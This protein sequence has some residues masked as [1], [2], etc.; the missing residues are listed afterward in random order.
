MSNIPEDIQQT[1]GNLLTALSSTDNAYR[2]QAELVLNNEWCIRDKVDILLVFLAEQ[3]ANAVLF[4]RFSIKSPN[5]QGFSV[6]DRQIDHISVPAKVEIRRLLLQ[7]FTSQQ[8]KNVRHKLADAIAE[9]A[10]DNFDWPELLPMVLHATSS[11]DAAMKESS[12]RMIATTPQIISKHDLNES[13]LKIIATCTAFVAFFEN[14][15]KSMWS[16]LSQLLPNLLN[17]LPRLLSSGNDTALASVLES[18]IDLVV[19]APK[20][21]KPMFETIISFCSQ[22]AQNTD[23]ESNARLTALELLTT[24]SETSPN[25]CKREP[26]YSTTMV[27]IT[28]K[29]MTEVCIDD[30]DC[31]EWNNTEDPTDEG[32]EDEY[33]AARQ[34]LD[35]VALKLNGQCL[36]TPLFQYLP[37]MLQSQN[38]RERQAALMALSSASE[39]CAD[40]LISEIPKLLDL[41]L[42]SL[43]DPQPRVQFACCN[44]LGQIFDSMLS[45]NNVP[46]VQTHAAAALVNFCEEA[47]KDI[48]EPYLD[49][50]LNNLLNLLKSSPKRYVQE[51]VITTIAV[52]ADAAENKFIKY[53]DTLMPL[54]VS[55][56]KSDVDSNGRTLI[57]KSIECATLIATAV[58]K[59][60]FSESANEILEIFTVLQNNLQGEDDPVKPYL[61]KGWSRVCK[62]IG[63]AFVPFLPGVIPPLL[64][65][66][67]ATQD[68]SIV[69]EDQLE[70]INQ[71]EDYEVIQL[72]GKHIAVHTSVLD[73]KASAI[74]I[75]KLYSEVLGSAFFPYVLEIANEIVIPG[76]D[77]YLH[78]GVRGTCAVTMPSLLKCCIESTGSSQS[79]ESFTIWKGMANKLISQLESDP[80]LELFFAY[81]YALSKCLDL[82]GPQALDDTQLVNLAKSIHGNLSDVYER[83][84]NHDEVDDDYNEEV[85]EYDE[86]CTD[87]ELLEE[88]VKGISAVFENSGPRSI[89]IFMTLAPVV[90]A[91]LKDENPILNRFAISIICDLVKFGGEQAFDFNDLFLN[92]VGTSLSSSDS[93]VR[94]MAAKCVG[95]CAQSINSAKYS[96]FALAC[97]PSLT[98]MASIPDARAP[99]NIEATEQICATIAIIFNATLAKIA[100]PFLTQLVNQQHEIVASKIPKI[101]DSVIQALLYASISDD[102]AVNAV[103]AVKGL[104]ATLPESQSMT[105]MNGYS[106]EA[107]AVI[108]KWFV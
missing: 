15:P 43:N 25:M 1:L 77:F 85:A 107:K 8:T 104:L 20:I 3:A 65:Q 103:S 32:D 52:V 21:F 91:F 29:L 28:L 4:R 83:I 87:E 51:Q 22:V 84:S 97:L 63:K 7:G 58:G 70:E 75:L 60:K 88:V 19:L 94:E 54:L 13:F 62:L 5:Y 31:S 66:A 80:A 6:T 18:L 47:T 24:F 92:P 33:N 16:V 56:M 93:K 12:F 108:S 59:E 44:A 45:T 49:D 30:D 89:P 69:E 48:V 101:V 95:L 105:I 76:L 41:V 78:D 55:V 35:R 81:Y 71:N 14:L 106:T 68:I 82:M 61:E 53:Y 26:S 98:Q 38:W 96:Q 9:V 79:T 99:D 86:D 36:A 39:G 90:S 10:K 46:R 34:A 37:H 17:S 2:K 42:P 64:E 72:S 11:N 73:D 50:L 23:L 40:V 100:Y 102:V 67:K 27:I 57:A 74:E